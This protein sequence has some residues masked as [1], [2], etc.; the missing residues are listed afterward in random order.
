M[1]LLAVT[2]SLGRALLRRSRMERE[3]DD[4]MWF[5]VEARAADLVARGLSPDEAARRARAEFGDAIRWK[6]QGRDARGLRVVDELRAD[7]C[8]AA[9]ML[10]RRPLSSASAIATLAI[11]IGL[12]A[13]V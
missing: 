11:G 8:Y 4:E 12:N 7:L 13:A 1:K 3:M 2:R 9:R 6:E 5:H 10:R